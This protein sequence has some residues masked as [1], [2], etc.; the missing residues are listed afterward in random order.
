MHFHISV[1]DLLENRRVYALSGDYGCKD[2]I[3]K[4]FEQWLFK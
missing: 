3:V 2:T 4:K 1:V